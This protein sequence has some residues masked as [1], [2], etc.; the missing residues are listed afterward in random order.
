LT[1]KSASTSNSTSKGKKRALEES[2]VNVG[3]DSSSSSNKSPKRARVEESQVDIGEIQDHNS[4]QEPASS[5]AAQPHKALPRPAIRIS[6]PNNPAQIANADREEEAAGKEPHNN[7]TLGRTTSVSDPRDKVVN[8]ER[9]EAI[10]R[11]NG[12]L[13]RKFT[14]NDFDD[15]EDVAAMKEKELS[16]VAESKQARASNSAAEP[17]KAPPRPTVC[18]GDPSDPAQMA[19]AGR[20]VG[21]EPHNNAPLDRTTS[22]SNSGDPKKVANIE[23]EETIPRQN[24]TLRRK[25]TINDFDDPEDVAAMKE[26]EL[27]C[28]AESK[29]GRASNSA[30]Q[31]HKAPLRPTTGTSNLNDPAQTPTTE[32]GEKVAEREPRKEEPLE[33]SVSDPNDTKVANIKREEGTSASDLNDPKKVANIKR[34]EASPRLGGNL[35]REVPAQTANAE[36]EEKAAERKLPKEEPLETSVSDLNDPKNVA[37]IKKEEAS[38]APEG[39]AGGEV[40]AT[41]DG[42]ISVGRWRNMPLRR[43]FVVGDLNDPVEVARA[44]MLTA[45]WVESRPSQRSGV[46]VSR[47]T[48]PRR[49]PPATNQAVSGSQQATGSGSGLAASTPSGSSMPG[50]RARDSDDG[51]KGQGRAQKKTRVRKNSDGSR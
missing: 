13:R 45:L 38:P 49:H 44:A 15:P 48:P 28:A 32:R 2:D 4:Q 1:T 46:D 41:A 51:D 34:E 24:G 10:P 40:A 7:A 11:Q 20:A 37:N 26:K 16:C 39:V 43:S 35:R 5:S 21:R 3:S 36:R 29:Q 9:E 17:P 8:I 6:D 18:I 30:A 12:A 14:I 42:R 33:T 50:K 31:S 23:R 27:S 47:V 22:V 19:N 25:F